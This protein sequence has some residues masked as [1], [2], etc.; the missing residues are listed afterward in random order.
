MAR[1][2]TLG[3]VVD[4]L[5]V[6]REKRLALERQADALNQNEKQL[7]EQLFKMLAD[8]GTT[9][10]RGKVATASRYLKS[11]AV[12]KDPKLFVSHVMKSNEWDL[13][14]VSASLEACQ[15]RWES[16]RAVPG[17][18]HDSIVR[19]SLTKNPRRK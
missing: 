12:V 14:R 17:V 16:D 15:G 2:K 18:E 7:R 4:A 1:S 11:L 6:L 13:I 9:I 5:Y 10:A 19:L 3:S 8:A